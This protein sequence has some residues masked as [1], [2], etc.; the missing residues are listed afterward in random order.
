M[1]SSEPL[2][3]GS[4]ASKLA[5]VQV[6]EV[7]E[8]MSYHH[9]EL[10]FQIKC[11]PCKGDLDQKTS[12]KDLG[13]TD[14][15]TY[16]LD[17]WL[18]Q[19]E[20]RITIHSAKDLPDPLPQGIQIVAITQNQNNEDVLVL[21][22]FE[23]AKFHPKNLKI[24]V[25]SQRREEGVSKLFPNALFCD[26][27]G[28]IEKRLEKVVSGELDGIAV[29]KVALMRLNLLHLNTIDLP[30][31]PPPLQGSLAILAREGDFEM[32]RLFSCVD[33]RRGKKSLFLGLDPSKFLSSGK[34]IHYPMIKICPRPKSE[35]LQSFFDLSEYTHCLFT[36]RSSVQIFLE[37]LHRLQKP[38]LLLNSKKVIAVGQSTARL[39]KKEGIYVDYIPQDESQ[40][41]LIALF[42]R[43]KMGKKSVIFYPKSSR[44]R[45]LLL[46]YYERKEIAFSAPDFYDTLDYLPDMKPNLEEIDEIV[47]TS[48]S[49]VK[50][51]FNHFTL[52]EKEI[53][54]VFK[55][56]V[57]KD[58]FNK[59]CTVK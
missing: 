19:R 17:Q 43:L 12:L 6:E 25:S 2:I 21:R 44:A 39:L 16:E 29:A 7:I 41:G 5:L 52:P 23:G 10:T 38:C 34:V 59:I 53:H 3:V 27:R 32:E 28:P 8:G 42:E 40:E 22:S 1:T 11:G 55:G 20:C 13:A 24:G 33:I 31:N 51:F 18:L 58:Y 30:I 56:K 45:P 15:F 26:L 54:F 9:P 57:T 37:C 35:L 4:R 48:P 49:V 14:F 36:S 50:S 46:D 47:F